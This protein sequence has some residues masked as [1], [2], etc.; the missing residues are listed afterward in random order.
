MLP[1]VI[2]TYPPATAATRQEGKHF[3][4]L[5]LWTFIPFGLERIES[6]PDRGRLEVMEGKALPRALTGVTF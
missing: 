3:K 4:P 1:G 6:L 2:G 5:D